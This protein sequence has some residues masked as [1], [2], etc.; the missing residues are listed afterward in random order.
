MNLPRLSDTLP[1]LWSLAVDLASEIHS[2]KHQAWPTLYPFIERILEPERVEAIYFAFRPL[3]PVHPPEVDAIFFVRMVQNLKIAFHE[4]RV[5]DVEGNRFLFRGVFTH[6]LR[7]LFVLLFM[8]VH[9][10]GRM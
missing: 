5:G 9:T 6:P 3:L 1:E 8:R 10:L 2:G 4:M 7:H